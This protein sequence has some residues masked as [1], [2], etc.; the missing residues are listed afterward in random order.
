MTSV[1]LGSK[2]VSP[3]VLS[4]EKIPR[5]DRRWRSKRPTYFLAIRVTDA[6]TI[7]NILDFQSNLVALH[8]ETQWGMIT[9]EKLHMTLFVLY[10]HSN[11]DLQ[12]ALEIFQAST[13]ILRQSHNTEKQMTLK[14]EGVGNFGS[15]R[16]VW[17]GL[18]KDQHRDTCKSVIELLFN[19]FKERAP[20]LVED[21]FELNPHITIY[22][23]KR[24]VIRTK[25]K[26]KQKNKTQ[27]RTQIKQ[28]IK[29]QVQQFKST[30]RTEKQN[31]N[32]QI[33][34]QEKRTVRE[35]RSL[36]TDIN[37]PSNL[38]EISYKDYAT[39][40]FGIQTVFCIDFLSMGEK[41]TTGYYLC[42]AKLY[43][44]N[45]IET[46]ILKSESKK[47]FKKK[48]S[49]PSYN[50]PGVNNILYFDILHDVDWERQ[51]ELDLSSK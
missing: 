33:L 16:V 21:N 41:D 11:K 26:N 22:K 31:Q 14:L 18:A 49:I 3:T 38:C 42:Y 39:T 32:E 8:P 29:E 45:Q 40:T 9:K 30:Q 43:L 37:V 35:K 24:K 10:I 36:Q 27:Q 44:S 2:K 47:L 4:Q 46:K 1:R 17:V 23:T 7:A 50:N 28:H 20:E 6:G 34:V 15:N 13:D 19:Q 5:P 51:E 12:Q 48:A 25:R